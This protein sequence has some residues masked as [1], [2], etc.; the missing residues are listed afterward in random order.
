MK[1]YLINLNGANNITKKTIGNKAYYVNLLEKI[2]VK[3]PHSYAISSEFLMDLIGSDFFDVNSDSTNLGNL[4]QKKLIDSKYNPLWNDLFNEIEDAYGVNKRIAIRSTSL[5]ED[6][7]DTASAGNY[8]TVLNVKMNHFDIVSGV[9]R[10]F[11]S[12]IK[13]K[14]TWKE[15]HV[16]FPVLVQEYI[17]LKYNGVAFSRNPLTME[18]EFIL[19]IGK[20]NKSVVN[21]EINYVSIYSIDN[22]Q[23]EE[24]QEEKQ[25]KEDNEYKDKI[26]ELIYEVEELAGFSKTGVDLE[27][28]LSQDGQLFVFQIRAI[29]TKPLF[30]ER[31]QKEKCFFIDLDS[32][33]VH[34]MGFPKF[35]KGLIS[36]QWKKRHWMKQIL[37]NAGINRDYRLGFLVF[38]KVRASEVTIQSEIDRIFSSQELLLIFETQ[39]GKKQNKIINRSEFSTSIDSIAM[40]GGISIVWVTEF[41]KPILSGYSKILNQNII[42]EYIVGDLIGLKNEVINYMSEVILSVN[43]IKIHE[44]I[45]EQKIQYSFDQTNNSVRVDYY[46][47]VPKISNEHLNQIRDITTTLDIE[48]RG[49][50][51]EWVLTDRGVLVYDMSDDKSV[52]ND[53]YQ[54]IEGYRVIS[55]GSLSGNIIELDEILFSKLAMQNKTLVSVVPSVNEMENVENNS[56]LKELEMKISTVSNPILLAPY[57]DISL[58]PL[59]N[60]VSG[61][62]FKSGSVL[63]HLSIHLRER[64][65]PAIILDERKIAKDT[66]DLII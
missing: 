59:L 54:T 10:V 8:T 53:N 46:E 43:G 38:D 3:T 60:K 52:I 6:N 20:S 27:W 12:Y 62:I 14:Y 29:T 37:R 17:D 57:P 11:E 28:G 32:D 41:H 56:I 19:E 65:V 31:A 36:K 9:M 15:K 13:Y 18:N 24:T 49:V 45:S 63:G 61:F 40:L 1:K 30:F 66:I 50:V 33:E 51:V 55:T 34:K 7:T 26:Q 21:G 39:D 44:C 2:K 42:I 25:F 23:V 35:Q 16:I 47:P 4:L 58:F 48:Y 22:E 64:K 5:N